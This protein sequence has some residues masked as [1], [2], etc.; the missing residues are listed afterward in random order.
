MKPKT[1]AIHP[2]KEGAGIMAEI[3]GESIHGK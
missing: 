2:D 1:N 3:I